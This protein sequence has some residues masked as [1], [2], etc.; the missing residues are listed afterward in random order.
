MRAMTGVLAVAGAL[1]ASEKDSQ[2]APGK[3]LGTRKQPLASAVIESAGLPS[4]RAAV[5]RATRGLGR[6]LTHSRPRVSAAWKA[7]AGSNGPLGS[8]RDRARERRPPA[9]AARR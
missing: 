5:H 2:A 8:A 3:L 6:A 4:P 1:L 7:R 9:P